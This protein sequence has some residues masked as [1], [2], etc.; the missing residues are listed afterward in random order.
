MNTSYHAKIGW[1]RD[2]VSKEDGKRSERGTFLLVCERVN[3]ARH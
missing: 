2:E 3:N 1:K